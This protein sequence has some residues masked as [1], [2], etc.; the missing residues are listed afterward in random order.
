MRMTPGGHAFP[1]LLL[2]TLDR[3]EQKALVPTMNV[4]DTMLGQ[5]WECLKPSVEL[6]YSILFKDLLLVVYAGLGKCLV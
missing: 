6:Q 5:V 3:T 4:V 1:L 2:A